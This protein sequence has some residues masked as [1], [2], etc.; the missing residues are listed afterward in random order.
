MK[1]DST[2]Q[3]DYIRFLTQQKFPCIA[4]KAAVAK[5]HIRCMVAHHMQCPA[6]DEA[7]LNFMYRFVDHYRASGQPYH[8]AAIFF[9]Q[10]QNLSEEEFDTLM[11]TRLKALS[12]LD[13]KQYNHDPRVDEDPSSSKFSF[14]L[15]EEA[16]FIIGLHPGSKREARRFN[17]PSLIFNPHAEFE[18]L[19]KSNRYDKMKEVVRKRDMEYSG[20][21]NPML[22]DFGE[23]SE[24]YQYSGVQHDEKWKCPLSN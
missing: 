15:K 2:I 19:R 10:P 7:I 20:S 14:S 5:N 24:I 3:N 18:R 8:S 4:A 13:K 1:E 11:W 9:R 17:Y 12:V 21:V 23:V 16:F 6:D 22:K